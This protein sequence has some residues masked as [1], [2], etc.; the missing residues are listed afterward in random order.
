MGAR[1][2]APKKKMIGK[3]GIDEASSLVNAHLHLNPLPCR[4]GQDSPQMLHPPS[5]ICT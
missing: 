2:C 5:M 4:E 3:N 1:V